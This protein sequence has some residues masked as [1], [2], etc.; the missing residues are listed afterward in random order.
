MK[1]SRVILGANLTAT[2][3][4]TITARGVV[5][6]LTSTNANPQI[7]GTGV[8]NVVDA[9]T[10]TGVFTENISGLTAGSGYSFVAY[11]TNS[12]GTTYTTPVS[13]FS[14]STSKAPRV[15]TPTSSRR[16]S[17]TATRG[18]TATA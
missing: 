12:A 5:Y 11:A 6:S 3:G 1:Y 18:V 14:T 16:R 7:G 15:A 2:G 17:T 13:T 9:S 8:T 4:A 10:A